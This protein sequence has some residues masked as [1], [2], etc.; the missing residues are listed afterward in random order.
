MLI[1]IC[2]ARPI[3]SS[4]IYTNTVGG[5]CCCCCLFVCLF[6]HV[7]FLHCVEPTVLCRTPTSMCWLCGTH[8]V[9]VV[10]AVWNTVCLCGGGC[11]K[12]SVLWWWLWET[13]CV[14][15]VAVWSTVCWCGGC[16]EHSVLMWWW[17]WGTQCVDVVAV[18]NTV[19]WCGAG[20]VEHSVLMWWW[21]WCI[22]LVGTFR[23]ILQQLVEV[24]N[25]KI[26][27]SLLD[28]NN[29]VMQVNTS[30]SYYRVGQYVTIILCQN[31][32]IVLS[33]RSGHHQRIIL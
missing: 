5:F 18:W 29:V 11:V 23:M 22:R 8:C 15:V 33:C 28:A 32:T 13:H 3:P 1:I 26:S 25:L 30:P 9:N 27:D 4:A 14:V 16:V 31:V 7:F 20:Y 24:G 2:T 10:V 19:C 12:H 21:L 17:L 6:F